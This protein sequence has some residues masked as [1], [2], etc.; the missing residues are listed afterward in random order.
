MCLSIF[1]DNV[2][3]YISYI[4]FFIIFSFVL[5]FN[6]MFTLVVDVPSP[7]N[8]IMLISEITVSLLTCF[9][10]RHF[11][12]YGLFVFSFCSSLFLLSFPYPSFYFLLFVIRSDIVIISL[13]FAL[14]F[15]SSTRLVLAHYLFLL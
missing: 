8:N 15:S 4:I 5:P 1:S 7:V 6:L 14:S 2:V 3:S 9:A 11:L 13:W 10:F 12:H